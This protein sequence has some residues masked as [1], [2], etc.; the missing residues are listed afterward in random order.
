[1]RKCGREV[2]TKMAICDEAVDDGGD[3][4]DDDVEVDGD[5]DGDVDGDVG[6]EVDG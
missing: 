6:V 4:D 3:D 2:D 5:G 1:M